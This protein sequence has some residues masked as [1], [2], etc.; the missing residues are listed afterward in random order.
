MSQSTVVPAYP[1]RAPHRL[2]L[3]PELGDIRRS[4]KIVRVRMPV[5]GEA[6]LVTRYHDVKTVLADPRFSRARAIG[7]DRP[8][9]SPEVLP[10]S[11]LISR[12]AADHQRVRRLVI[13]AFT[14]RRVELFRPRVVE[15]MDRAIDDL[16]AAGTPADFVEHVATPFP[17]TL[18]CD[19]LGMEITDRHHFERLAEMLR[20]RDHST[21]EL[22][23]ARRDL[24][25]YLLK[26]IEQRRRDP[27]DD[28]ID[29]LIAAQAAEDGIDDDELMNLIVA[30]LLG[31]SGSPANALTSSMY[32]LS[33]H[34]DAWRELVDDPAKIPGAVEEL[35]RFIPLGVAGGFVRIA[36][37]DVEIGGEVIRS[38]DAVVPAMISGNV[39]EEVFEQADRLV[40]SRTRNPHLGFGH[41]AHHC[42][43][44]QLA[45]LEMRV[46]LERLTARLPG[47][48]VADA[49]EKLRWKRS[50]VNRGLDALPVA[51]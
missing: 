10:A 28:L 20:R 40:I 43:G 8:R 13:R 33:R 12:D 14:A 45:R 26:L 15:T 18:I 34:P 22:H 35:L 6:W 3:D 46:A 32:V 16:T 23:Q 17:Y 48:R 39:D 38:G 7:M 5:G 1:F 19:F 24:E 30:I 4:G 11:A 44:A 41:G 29:S 36:T 27:R 42:L 2:D 9:L 51:W 25:T 31:G 50:E 21:D 49:E 37:E 47:L